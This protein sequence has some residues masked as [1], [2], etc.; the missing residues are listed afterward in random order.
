MPT[1][2]PREDGSGRERWIATLTIAMLVLVPVLAGR[3]LRPGW[4]HPFTPDDAANVSDDQAPDAVPVVETEPP[5][6]LAPTDPNAPW[7][8]ETAGEVWSQPIFHGGQI[9]VGSDDGSGYAVDTAGRERWQVDAGGK[10]GDRIRSKVRSRAAAADGLVVWTSGGGSVVAA[11]A[12]SGEERWRSS[13]STARTDAAPAGE[14]IVFG[15]ETGLTALDRQTGHAVWTADVG[16]VAARPAAD[17]RRVV[18]GTTDGR[19]VA[20]DVRNGR[21]VWSFD[22]GAEISTPP[23]IAGRFVVLTSGDGS[24]FCVEAITGRVRWRSGTSEFVGSAPAVAD[25][26]VFVGGGDGALW[27]FD[28][29]SGLGLWRRKLAEPVRGTPFAHGDT[30]W[31]AAG[32]RYLAAVRASDGKPL[33]VFAV[34]GWVSSSPIVAAPED[35]PE[36]LIFPTSDGSVHGV[37]LRLVVKELALRPS[38]EEAP[39]KARI[40]IEPTFHD[41]RPEIVWQV[42]LPGRSTT[43][44]ALA[45]GRVIVAAARHLVALDALSGD[46][47]WRATESDA[48]GGPPVAADGQ[49]LAPR[50]AGSNGRGAL[51]AFDLDDGRRLWRTEVDDDVTSRPVVW[52]DRVIFGTAGGRLIATSKNDGSVLWERPTDGAMNAGPAVAGGR[53]FGI[54]IAGGCDGAVYGL[55]V[56]DG[57]ELWRFRTGSCVATDIVL[58]EASGQEV[59]YVADSGGNVYALDPTVG[60][61]L[62]RSEL[63]GGA[64]RRP[65]IQGGTLYLG[66]HA[67]EL[68]SLSALHGGTRWRFRAGGAVSGGV[69]VDL[70]IAYAASND[71][72]LHAVGAIN[73]QEFWRLETPH[74]AYDVAFDDGTVYVV[75]ASPDGGRVYALRAP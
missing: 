37:P 47:L 29:D 72:A 40:V 52:R 7:R 57:R 62:W 32:E 38:A 42:D 3:I 15:T 67:G 5:E 49:I 55:S 53:G 61:E 22:A 59:A 12:D 48:D 20:V 13:I 8:F 63:E 14:R 26:R 43:A 39:R 28:L 36:R 18:A 65:E 17:G 45:S 41:G 73:G 56:E 33:H 9:L 66:S 44:P 1:S 34:D 31:M 58:A 16:P 75:T 50:R 24:V 2:D 54:V 25:G 10:A 68:R 51:V 6:E 21:V 11:D 19:L 60:G 46:E 27:A 64:G 70:G 71:G 35:G 30:L 69:V 74:P 23:T 4:P